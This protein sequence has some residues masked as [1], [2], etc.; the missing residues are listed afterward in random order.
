M[1]QL[2]TVHVVFLYSQKE[3]KYYYNTTPLKASSLFSSTISIVHS[4]VHFVYFATRFDKSV[5]N[6]WKTFR[7]DPRFIPTL[8]QTV[9]CLARHPILTIEFL[10]IIFEEDFDQI[11]TKVYFNKEV[12]AEGGCL[13]SGQRKRLHGRPVPGRKSSVET[14]ALRTA[15]A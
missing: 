9:F 3:L 8:N 5:Q 15:P 4:K 10:I 2:L 14:W 6:K 13:R 12:G 7:Y 1:Q 11:S